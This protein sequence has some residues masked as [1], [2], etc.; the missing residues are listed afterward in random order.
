MDKKKKIIFIC[1]VIILLVL[2]SIG[3]LSFMSY[4]NNETKG[5]QTW[6][7]VE[8]DEEKEPFAYSRIISS[9]DE[10]IKAINEQYYNGE[11][12][13]KLTDDTDGCYKATGPDKVKYSYCSG[14][15]DISIEG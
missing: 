11:E 6:D 5:N 9:S 15:D 3:V 2:G 14:A 10:F 4:S 13:A 12:K 8:I 7:D 1:L